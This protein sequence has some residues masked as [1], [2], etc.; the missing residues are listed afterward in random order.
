MESRGIGLNPTA[1]GGWFRSGDR[2]EQSSWFSFHSY[3]P[4]VSGAEGIGEK[5]MVSGITQDRLPQ[6]GR[7][8]A[9]APSRSNQQTILPLITKIATENVGEGVVVRIYQGWAARFFACQ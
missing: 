4:F 8:G 9:V 7:V 2:H 6:D 3:V 1:G 5:T